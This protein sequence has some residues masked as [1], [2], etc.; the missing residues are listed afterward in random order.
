MDPNR[1]IR[2]RWVH[3][4]SA[5]DITYHLARFRFSHN[6]PHTWQP[7]INAYR[8][9]TCV[10]ICVDLAGVP[11]AE[12]DLLVEPR[13]VVIRGE[14]DTSEPPAKGGRVHQT[15]A[16]EIEYGP[17]FRAIDLPVEVDVEKASAEQENGFL[18]ISLPLAKS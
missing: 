14:R 5:G 9:E 1:T 13:R 12:I 2:L 18:W 11:K 6:T 4:A 3:G 8:C 7:S 17:F 15:I 16:M 10:R